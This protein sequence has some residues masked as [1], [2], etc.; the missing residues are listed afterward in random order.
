MSLSKKYFRNE[1]V[2][3]REIEDEYVMVPI[4]SGIGDMD[5]TVHTLNAMGIAIW[6]KLS[7][8]KTLETIVD[9]LCQETDADKKEIKNDIT[10]FIEELLK[11]KL[12]IC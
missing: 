9:E 4:E 5:G 8:D 11:R 1:D 12:I 10:G 6:E 3:V 7:P 2:I